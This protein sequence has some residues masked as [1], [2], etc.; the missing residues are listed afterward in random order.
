MVRNAIDHGI[1][2]EKDRKAFGKDGQGK[3]D[4]EI[5]E[6]DEFLEI[7]I[8]DDGAGLDL[9]AIKAKTEN[10]DDMSKEDLASQIFMN[11]FST[12]ND[13]S[14]VSGRGVGMAAVKKI[15]ED[16]GGT[17]HVELSEENQNQSGRWYFEF[18]IKLQRED[19]L[20]FPQ[21]DQVS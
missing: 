8:R 21:L 5:K 12:K 1:E 9:D 11:N 19:F 4:V 17:I 3:I 10:S 14:Q 6:L 7:V 18:I 13:V 20:S 15:I 16:A 2:R